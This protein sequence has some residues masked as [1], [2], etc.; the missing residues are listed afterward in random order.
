MGF[1]LG[2]KKSFLVL[3]YLLLKQ[4]GGG[5]LKLYTYFYGFQRLE[6]GLSLQVVLVVLHVQVVRGMGLYCKL[7]NELSYELGL[8]RKPG[9]VVIDSGF[10]G[11]FLGLPFGLLLP[12]LLRFGKVDS[13][14]DGLSLG[15]FFGLP[16]VHFGLPGSSLGFDNDGLG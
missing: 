9:F 8:L 13:G 12:G 15:I 16:G 4:G 6:L 3:T 7:Q 10:Q 5:S 2:Q 14:P 11:R 1:L